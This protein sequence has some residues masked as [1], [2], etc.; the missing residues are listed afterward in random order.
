M[1]PR[2]TAEYP[3]HAPAFLGMESQRGDLRKSLP[4]LVCMKTDLVR[5]RGQEIMSVC[6]LVSG[7]EEQGQP[8]VVVQNIP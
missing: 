7:C 5:C 8:N 2:K 6:A 4:A 1:L 3:E